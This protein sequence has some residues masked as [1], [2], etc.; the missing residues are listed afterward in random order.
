MGARTDTTGGKLIIKIA[1]RDLCLEGTVHRVSVFTKVF[2][3]IRSGISWRE[4]E[5]KVGLATGFCKGMHETVAFKLA[6]FFF[7]DRSHVSF[8]MHACP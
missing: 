6:L 1:P 7:S 8:W 2:L 3:L 4:A 5:D